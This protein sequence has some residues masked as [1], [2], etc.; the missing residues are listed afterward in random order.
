MSDYPSLEVIIADNASRDGSI[1]AVRGAFSDKRLR[2]IVNPQ[3]LGYAA[4]NNVGVRFAK[5][6]YIV[7]LNNDVQVDVLWLKEIIK[8]MQNNPGIGACQPKLLKYYDITRIDNVGGT[9]D[10]CGFSYGEV[11]GVKD[12]G[13]FNSTKEIFVAVGSAL[14]IKREVLEQI[15]LFDPDYFAFYDEN[16]LCWRVW[17]RGYKILLIPTS[18]VYHVGSASYRK[19]SAGIS[20]RTPF[21]ATKNH[22]STLIK[23]YSLKNLLRYLPI[24]VFL[25]LAKI[26][27]HI[28]S[29]DYRIAFADIQG[30]VWIF[31][32]LKHL[33]SK[34]IRVQR[35]IRQVSDVYLMKYMMRPS[36]R[37]LIKTFSIIYGGKA[38]LKNIHN[39][40]EKKYE[41][42]F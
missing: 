33:Y 1:E 15:G 39:L 8:V 2:I 10:F 23:N 40:K 31:Q 20:E 13:Q 32:N 3:N 6:D 24:S 17:L 7:F 34:R 30:I 16:D 26:I 28:Y 25:R 36:L 5:G 4:G 22:L 12:Y 42:N 38:S 9:I 14:V 35:S 19:Y 29:R 18:V 21:H 41:K 27:I 37:N 11:S